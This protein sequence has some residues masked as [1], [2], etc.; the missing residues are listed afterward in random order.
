MYIKM[1]TKIRMMS[2]ADK[3]IFWDPISS[4]KQRKKCSVCKHM[5]LWDKPYPDDYHCKLLKYRDHCGGLSSYSCETLCEQDCPLT[6][7]GD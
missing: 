6:E 3:T 1:K 7:L 4:E 2:I 5:E